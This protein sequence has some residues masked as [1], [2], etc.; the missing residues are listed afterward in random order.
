MSN[1]LD[2]RTFLRRGALGAA[3][4]AGLAVMGGGGITAVLDSL[5]QSAGASVGS[6]AS[7]GT[8]DY[9]LSWIKNVEFAGQYLADMKGYYKNVGFS[10][11]NFISGGPTVQQ[12]AVVAAGKAFIGISSPDI[13]GPAILQGAPLIAVGAL[14]QKNPFAMMSLKSSPI[15]TPKD[16]IGKKIGV[17]AVND[18]V[19]TAFLK[20]NKID[21]GKITKVPVQFDPS[22][23]VAKEVD[24]WFSFFTN[25]PNLLKAKGV[26]TTVFLLND[27][28]YPLV[29]QIYVVRKDTLKTDR[30]KI[31][32]IL[33]ADILGWHDS[34]KDP[35]AGPNLVVSKYGADLG[36]DQ[37]EQTLESNSQN[38]L[39]L[40]P[41]TKANGILTMTPALQA[42]NV[43]TLALGGTKIKA[44]DLFD[45]SLLSEVYAK[46]P[47]LK[48]SPV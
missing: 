44:K 9:Q 38:T 10:S 26:D 7:F 15:K 34:L 43:K 22:P 27:F 11:A 39:I 42:A 21:A 14:F 3:G 18:P 13:T 2:R 31:K 20:A 19:W 8:L 28:N 17:Q 36:L 16:M 32:A 37:S 45:L 1:Q 41:D 4:T 24:G 25:E 47:A 12:D 5:S 35:A 46:M 30:E 48:K 40:T 29:S 33:Q 23:L 6:A